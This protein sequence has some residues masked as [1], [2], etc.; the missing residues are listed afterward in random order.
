MHRFSIAFLPVLS[1][2]LLVSN[3]SAQ[4]PSAIS[5]PNLIR[6]SGS[7][8]GLPGAASVSATTL[9]I[10]FAVYRQ[11]DGGAPIWMETQNVTTDASGNYSVLL[12][13]TTA[14]G[15]P[16]DLFSQ[17]E[18]RWLGVQVQGQAEQPRVLMV[19]VPYAFKAHEAE[20]LG[21]R[22]VSDFVLNNSATSAANNGSDGLAV[23]LIANVANSKSAGSGAQKGA[24]DE[25]PTN[26][27]G[28]T[29][30]Q[31]VAVS[32]NGTGM[33]V[34]VSALTLGI[35]GTATAASGTAYGVQGVASSTAGVG[36]IGTATS[37]TGFTYGLRGTSSSS[38]GTGVRGIATATDGS[39]TGVSGYVD[40]AS[41][42][43]GAFN[44]A[45]GGKILSGQNNGTEM[46]SVD[47]GGNVNAAGGFTGG[48][49]GLTGIQFSQL[50]G[51]LVSSQLGGS[52]SQAVTLSSTSNVLYG[53]GANLTGVPVGPGSPNY[54]QNG[55][56]QQGNTNFNISGNGTAAG[57]LAGNAVNSGTSY[58][59]GGAG[60]MS[61]GSSA[62][63]NLFLGVGAGTNNIAGSGQHNAFIGYQAGLHNSSGLSNFFAG[64]YA[65]TSNTTGCCNAFSGYKAGYSNTIASFNVFSGWKAGYS[66]TVGQ[67]DTFNGYEAGYS[68]TGDGKDG[69]ND[70]IF[71]GFEAG[72]RNTL[73]SRNTFS[74]SQA[75]YSNTGDGMGLGENNA[76]FG[77][78]AGYSNT[79]GAE[80]TFIGEMAG[81]SNTGG[82]MGEVGDNNTFIGQ[83]AGYSNTL[84]S[85]NTFIGDTAGY[86]N[87]TGSNDVY[88]G[89][90]G[91]NSG[92]ES[93]TLRIGGLEGLFAAYIQGIYGITASGGIPVYI[94][95]DGQ[96]GTQT[97]SLR[98]KEQVQDMGHS[99]DALMKLRPVTFLYKPEYSKGDRTLQYGLIAEEVAQVYPE[100]V[101]YDND[102]QP[103]TVRYQYLSTML[104]NEVQKQY[105]R[106][107]EQARVIMEQQAQLTTQQRQIADLT[108]Q[109]E[110]ENASLRERL[111]RLERE[112]GT[113]AETVAAA[114]R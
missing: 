23:S 10:T 32:Q 56:S 80:N 61:I 79:L 92:T 52:Y 91:P 49:A 81:Y 15:L 101:A 57:M 102:G 71:D 19:S 24:D 94:N 47:G 1:T 41:G 93:N 36:L 86:Y 67:H 53:N 77:Y 48:G 50:T 9:G 6:Y 34:V 12:G 65:G 72:Y 112:L 62:D 97:S 51:Q 14:S 27:S 13:G 58:Q 70:N 96:L 26:F 109:L 100:L 4:Q 82:T 74:G 108:R 98:F 25:G 31:I 64:A 16:S 43:A 88:I 22:S 2:V 55:T 73:G 89:V 105:R 85:E 35:Q 20:T 42:T 59:I 83:A 84:G 39:T 113:Q 21:G 3:L 7:L 44:N 114:K 8:N 99:T 78:Q 66:N 5:V 104:L 103:Y 40:S 111:T 30:D 87:V 76:F 63:G 38:S 29:T 17:Q 60:V 106:A 107:D 46:F 110:T 54:I 75:G 28:S 68:N 69:G 33:G 95:S 45:A 11:Q 90:A 18:Q 37:D